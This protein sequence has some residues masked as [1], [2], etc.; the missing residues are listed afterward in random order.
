M[1]KLIILAGSAGSIL[2]ITN[3]IKGLSSKMKC[4]I[5]VLVHQEEDCKLEMNFLNYMSK[6]VVHIEDGTKILDNHIYIAPPMYH[7]QVERDFTFSFTCDDPVM[8]SRPSIDILLETAGYA[9]QAKL[10]SI[11]L[12][13]ASIDGTNGASIASK[14]GAKVLVQSL[15]EAV[16]PK[17][18]ASVLNSV[19]LAKEMKINEV[20][21]YLNE[22]CA[23]YEWY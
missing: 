19:P 15:S 5:V 7:L 3:I 12:S 22:G 1:G 21:E 8:F 11:I 23:K 2:P 18:P 9:Y 4:P 13:G 14:Y 16:E 17:M 20:I 6:E 10:V